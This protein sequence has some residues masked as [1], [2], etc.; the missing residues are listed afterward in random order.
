MWIFG[1]GSLMWDGWE[2]KFSCSRRSAAIL[3]GYSRTF[4]KASVKNWGSRAIPGPTLNLAATEGA[5][6]NGMA[7]EFRDDLAD[8]VMAYLAKREGGF[9][10]R[11][12]TITLPDGAEVVATVPIYAQGKNLLV[13]KSAAELVAM[14]RAARGESGSCADYVR[15]VARLLRDAGIEDAA[16]EDFARALD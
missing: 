11:P 8:S 15:N 2:Q 10:L 6:C 14:I 5:R 4:N 16:V 3:N 9:E 12:L 13:D 1:F 7:F